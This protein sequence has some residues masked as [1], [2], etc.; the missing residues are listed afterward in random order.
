MILNLE[1]SFKFVLLQFVTKKKSSFDKRDVIVMNGTVM[2]K[3]LTY[4]CF[5]EYI[6][7]NKMILRIDT[8]EQIISLTIKEFSLDIN[9]NEYILSLKNFLN[10]LSEDSICEVKK[11]ID[12]ITFNIMHF[13]YYFYPGMLFHNEYED[14]KFRQFL[15]KNNLKLQNGSILFT[16]DHNERN[17]LFLQES[18]DDLLD[19]N[20]DNNP[21]SYIT[22]LSINN[23]PFLRNIDMSDLLWDKNEVSKFFMWIL[24]YKYENIHRIYDLKI[25]Q[26]DYKKSRHYY[27]LYFIRKIDNPSPLKITKRMFGFAIM[28]L[29]NI[30]IRIKKSNILISK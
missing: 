18:I 25:K 27:M 17:K 20:L 8:T 3:D 21:S 28:Q 7:L 11:S 22:K 26:Y 19:I 30:G 16:P 23:Y 10:N 6:K 9:V 2:D 5:I 12:M 4:V 15:I 29:M 13:N 1:S 24:R 14:A